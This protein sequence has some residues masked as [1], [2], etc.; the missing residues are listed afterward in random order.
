VLRYGVA[1]R[2]RRYTLRRASKAAS[3]LLLLLLPLPLPGRRV[4]LCAERF[5]A[6]E[7]TVADQRVSVRGCQK[8]NVWHSVVCCFPAGQL[9]GAVMLHPFECMWSSDIQ[10]AHVQYVLLSKLCQPSL[11]C[12]CMPQ[13]HLPGQHALLH[14]Q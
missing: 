4:T 7:R 9:K 14:P 6:A 12:I 5:D 11:G 13:H 10:H 3:A 8:D 1:Q 2:L